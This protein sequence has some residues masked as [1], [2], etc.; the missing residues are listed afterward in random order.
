MIGTGGVVPALLCACG[1]RIQEAL[2]LSVA[3]RRTAGEVLFGR[4]PDALNIDAVGLQACGFD[5][6]TG[7]HRRIAIACSE[8]MR[9]GLEGAE[10][11]LTRAVVAGCVGR[12]KQQG[13]AL[14]A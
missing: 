2:S 8:V 3:D 12:R 10:S 1:D 11:S 14:L 5:L 7:P 6:I 4:K 13:D 9:A